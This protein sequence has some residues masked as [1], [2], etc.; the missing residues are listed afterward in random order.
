[1][2]IHISECDDHVTSRIKTPSQKCPTC[3]KFSPLKIGTNSVNV[4]EFERLH[5]T[6]LRSNLGTSDRRF[7]PLNYMITFLRQA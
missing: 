6:H 1:M 4:G 2:Y 7:K 3:L 5:K